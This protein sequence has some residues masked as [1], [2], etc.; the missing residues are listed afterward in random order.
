MFLNTIQVLKLFFKLVITTKI[1][2]IL[3]LKLIDYNKNNTSCVI[4]TKILP[5]KVCSQNNPILYFM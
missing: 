2:L 1:G 4:E 5:L 3:F